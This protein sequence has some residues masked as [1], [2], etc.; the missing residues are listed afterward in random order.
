VKLPR[1]DASSVAVK[2][3]LVPAARSVNGATFDAR[4]EMS[5]A[6]LPPEQRPEAWHEAVAAAPHRPQDRKEEGH[7]QARA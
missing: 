7:W 2:S 4:R 1:E 6:S 5:P 3:T